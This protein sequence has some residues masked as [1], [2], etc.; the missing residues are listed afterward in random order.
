[1]VSQSR[2][3]VFHWITLLVDR[4]EGVFRRRREDSGLSR[5]GTAEGI[6]T[7]SSEEEEDRGGVDDKGDHHE[8]GDELSTPCTK[9]RPAFSQ[10][11]TPCEGVRSVVLF[12]GGCLCAWKRGGGGVVCWQPE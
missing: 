9:V 5:C 3:G 12:V 1:M 4:S 2:L 10:S 8:C 6:A 11:Q 7:S